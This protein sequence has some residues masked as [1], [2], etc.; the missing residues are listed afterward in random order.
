VLS[1][2]SRFGKIEAFYSDRGDENLLVDGI[3]MLV[4]HHLAFD[5]S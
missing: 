5:A 3:A 1:T 4:H 2:S